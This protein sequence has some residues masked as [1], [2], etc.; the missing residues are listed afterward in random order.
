MLVAVAD[1]AFGSLATVIASPAIA[2]L[3]GEADHGPCLVLDTDRN[4][5]HPVAFIE[6][7]AIAGA[8]SNMPVERC[9]GLADDR[10]DL[11]R[12]EKSTAVRGNAAQSRCLP[13]CMRQSITYL[14]SIMG[15]RAPRCGV[16]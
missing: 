15:P 9:A 4:S 12:T 7:R 14:P 6:W 5:R 10:V 8:R 16:K 13:S 1:A 2:Y 3:L 11:P